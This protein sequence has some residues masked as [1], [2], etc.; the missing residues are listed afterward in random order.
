MLSY[1]LIY[2]YEYNNSLPMALEYQ[3]ITD[4]SIL[5]C[6]ICV[7]HVPLFFYQTK[8]I[9]LYLVFFEYSRYPSNSF[10]KVLSSSDVLINIRIMAM[11]VG[12][13]LQNDVVIKG[14]E[15]SERIIPK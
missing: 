7:I 6:S 2:T 11:T 9:S 12:I 3:I 8:G 5:I 4:P 14:I 13:V 1:Q 15:T 10:F